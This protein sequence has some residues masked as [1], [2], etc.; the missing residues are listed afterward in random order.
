MKEEK[1]STIS[2]IILGLI[3]IVG[4]VYWAWQADQKSNNSQSPT[5]A[6]YKNNLG[7]RGGLPQLIPLDSSSQDDK[8]CPDD[9]KVFLPSVTSGSNQSFICPP[10]NEGV[11]YHENKEIQELKKRLGRLEKILEYHDHNKNE[12]R[13]IGSYLDS[14]RLEFDCHQDIH[15]KPKGKGIII[16]TCVGEEANPR[17]DAITWSITNQGLSLVYNKEEA[18]FLYSPDLQCGD[19]YDHQLG[20]Y[21]KPG[22]TAGVFAVAPYE[23]NL[24]ILSTYSVFFKSSEKCK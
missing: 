12:S 1:L 16:S 18:L 20:K 22:K 10:K 24:S 14:E 17:S 21:I 13:Y 6:S 19:Y 5:P 8:N 23:D 4:G 15:L 11:V 2:K 7:G 9:Q 3:I